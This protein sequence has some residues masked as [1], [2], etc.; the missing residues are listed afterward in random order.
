MIQ[1][2]L[3]C[4][5]TF[6]SAVAIV[7]L[8]GYQALRSVVFRIPSFFWR[9]VALGGFSIGCG[10]IAVGAYVYASFSPQQF[11]WLSNLL[12][13]KIDNPYLRALYTGL[14]VITIIRS[15]ALQI[16]GADI[17]F[18]YFYGDLR[19]KTLGT[20]LAQWTEYRNQFIR[21]NLEKIFQYPNVDVEIKELIESNIEFSDQK[22][23]SSISSQIEEIFK[24]RPSTL[25]DQIDPQ[26]RAFY[27]S[28][29]NLALT[30]CGADA[31]KRT[32][33]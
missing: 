2:S 1:I 23:K 8:D 22:Y 27:R 7:Y 17:G 15:K 4:A 11:E 32:F 25:Q 5:I 6:I 19:A 18:E 13:A 28:L 9:S 31:L 24:N 12:G 26:W 29:M 30:N 16:R 20:I 33:H 10:L 21:D 3:S 14:A